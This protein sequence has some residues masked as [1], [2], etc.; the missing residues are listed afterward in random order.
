[1]SNYKH[2]LLAVDFSEHSKEVVLKAKELADY[3]QAELS[4]IHVV[5]SVPLVDI[6][7]ETAMPFDYDLN[8]IFMNS[9]KAKLQELARDLELSFKESWLELGSPKTEI[10]RIATENAVDLIV[11]GSHGRHGLGLLLGSTA[12]AVLHH[13]PCDV[14]AVRLKDD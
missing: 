1:M 9:A 7:Y 8:E 11:V 2:I 14:L 12:N 4:L 3:Y 5:D 6:G 13:A 10:V